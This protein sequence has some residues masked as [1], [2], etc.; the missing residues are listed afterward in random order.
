VYQ[1]QEN[2][3]SCNYKIIYQIMKRMEPTMPA[4]MEQTQRPQ[5]VIEDMT[6]AELLLDETFASEHFNTDAQPD[7]EASQPLHEEPLQGEDSIMNDAIWNSIYPSLCSLARY[8]VHTSPLPCWRGQEDDMANDIVQ[9]TVRRVIER[10]EKARRGEAPPIRSLKQMATTVAYNYYRDLKRHDYRVSR[11]E[12]INTSAHSTHFYP[13]D[14]H[15]DEDEY[16]LDTVS[17][18]VDQDRLFDI[19]ASEIGRFPTKQKQA[20]LTDLANL[21]AFDCEPTSLQASFLNIGI[22]LRHYRRPLPANQKERSR[23]IS[24]C[25]QAYKRVAHLSCAQQYA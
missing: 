18:K 9:E 25:S 3:A 11:L 17:E 23:H 14:A 13:L 6:F 22:E 2:T 19:L 10:A 1:Q 12:T 5:P 20:I 16:L 8:L 24:L 21:M 7:T 4:L 15:S